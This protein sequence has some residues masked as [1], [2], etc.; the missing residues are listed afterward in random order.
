MLHAE[1]YEKFQHDL[2][3]DKTTDEEE[4]NSIHENSDGSNNNGNV[5]DSSE[6][7]DFSFI[8]TEEYKMSASGKEINRISR[9]GFVTCSF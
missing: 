6:E 1:E 4:T 2:Q 8:K 7:M 9:I 5:E 3:R